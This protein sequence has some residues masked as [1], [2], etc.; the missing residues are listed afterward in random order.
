MSPTKKDRKIQSVSGRSF[1]SKPAVGR[2]GAGQFA[3]VIGAA[4]HQEY[5]GTHAAVKTIVGLT[6]ANERAVK[7]WFDARNGPSGEFL[8]A[9]CRHS[10]QVLEAVLVLAGRP[11]L[12]TANNLINVKEKLR[13]MLD[14]IDALE[15]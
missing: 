6:G 8:I 15:R 7:N 10:D 1:Q 3:A 4:L 9:L 14:L 5:G 13:E 12:V 2:L 11:E